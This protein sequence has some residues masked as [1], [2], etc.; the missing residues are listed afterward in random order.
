MSALN[1]N[2]FYRQITGEND[3]ALKGPGNLWHL[4]QGGLPPYGFMTTE[5]TLMEFQ[6]ASEIKEEAAG[7]TGKA[8]SQRFINNQYGLQ[9]VVN[10]T[11]Y[12]ASKAVKYQVTLSLPITAEPVQI[13]DICP[14]WLEL[15]FEHG[16]RYRGRWMTG[17]STKSQYPTPNYRENEVVFMPGHDR[18]LRIGSTTEDAKSSG[19]YLP[20]FMVSS[21]RGG[22]VCGM[23]WSGPWS[24]VLSPDHLKLWGSIW[25]DGVPQEWSVGEPPYSGTPLTLKPG[26]TLTLPTVHLVFFEGDC[27]S[28]SNALRRYLHNIHC[29]LIN[30]EPVLPPLSYDHWFGIATDFTEDFLRTQAQRA[31]ELGL[32]IFVLDA[33]WYEGCQDTDNG[34][35]GGMGNW[36]YEEKKIFPNGIEPFSE[37]ISS[38]G[39]KFG[40]FFEIVG[41]S[42]RQSHWVREHPEWFFDCGGDLLYINL[43]LP[44]VQEHI[45]NV[46]A[47]WIERLGLEWMRWEIAMGPLLMS[48]KE[49]ETRQL[50]FK[51]QK[52][53]F[54]VWDTLLSRYPGVIFELCAEGG[55]R[56]DMATLKRAH[57]SWFTDTNEEAIMCRDMQCGANRFLPG[58]FL[59]SAISVSRGVGDSGLNEA[60]ILS[61]MCGALSFSGDVASL[62][63][64]LTR[65]F[66]RLIQVYKG[67][68]HLLVQDFYSLTN[69]PQKPE[70]GEAVIFVSYDKNE[71]VLLAYS[72]LKPQEKMFLRFKGLDMDK[73]YLI[74][75]P[76]SDNAPVKMTGR[77]MHTEGFGVSMEESAAIR[78]IRADSCE[79]FE[80]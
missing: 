11:D 53:L 24:M 38:L 69:Q 18:G 75:D 12:S 61:R 9:A 51:Y 30:G 39:L 78:L 10:L 46:T 5:G 80:S 42:Y 71:A 1:F 70:D 23:E 45:I 79:E 32:E 8:I 50:I 55:H 26:E 66:A 76:V 37:Y 48:M 64:G 40:M 13:S 21:E 34:F 6:S 60:A 62:S 65:S 31:L 35:M 28:G 43:A 52:G 68:R 7:D 74:S 73:C 17:G 57:T 33:G 14:L 19:E 2:D 16:I 67:F 47:N 49:D 59:N 15:P 3:T 29:P 77:E 56:I 41:R 44:E 22:V 36:E 63:E 27:D 72:G 4:F 25:F 20:F 58:N 54:N